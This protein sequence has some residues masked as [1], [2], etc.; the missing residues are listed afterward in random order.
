MSNVELLP[1]LQDVNP[2]WLYLISAVV[3]VGVYALISSSR[4]LMPFGLLVALVFLAAGFPTVK[5]RCLFIHG[6]AG[7]DIFCRS[8]AYVIPLGFWMAHLFA[9]RLLA[10]VK[11]FTVYFLSSANVAA[12]IVVECFL[13][14]RLYEGHEI[15]IWIGVWVGCAYIWP[16]CLAILSEQML[17]ASPIVMWGYGITVMALGIQFLTEYLGHGWLEAR[18]AELGILCIVAMQV[19]PFL[20]MEISGGRSNYWT[21]LLFRARR[22]RQ[23]EGHSV[24]R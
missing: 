1:Y 8:L 10:Q 21:D 23:T 12:I 5:Y 16:L 22:A 18:N 9:H 14:W 17:D 20:V 3:G 11:F 4:W 6:G 7:L 19:L 24:N 15:G 13:R 2:F